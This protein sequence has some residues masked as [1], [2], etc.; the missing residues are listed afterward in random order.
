MNY[1]FS[2]I[3]LLEF[4]HCNVSKK[5]KRRKHKARLSSGPRPESELLP[6][7]CVISGSPDGW[8]STECRS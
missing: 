4:V 2:T 3:G 8:N 6:Y 7:C 1:G 5:S